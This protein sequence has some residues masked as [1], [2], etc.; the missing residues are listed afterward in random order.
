MTKN[1]KYQNDPPVRSETFTIHKHVDG[2]LKKY[3]QVMNQDWKELKQYF[4]INTDGDEEIYLDAVNRF[5][6]SEG[7]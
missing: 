7:F 2:R 4:K 6:S 3:A 5:L 1:N